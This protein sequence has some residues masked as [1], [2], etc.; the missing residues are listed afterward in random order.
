MIGLCFCAYL[1][2]RVAYCPLSL[3]NSMT[4]LFC[5]QVTSILL[6]RPSQF[7]ANKPAS[8][9]CILATRPPRHKRPTVCHGHYRMA[10]PRICKAVTNHQNNSHQL[11][12]GS[13]NQT[14]DSSHLAKL[15]IELFPL[16]A[17][18][19]FERLFPVPASSAAVEKVFSRTRS[20]PRSFGVV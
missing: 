8:E 20:R 14:A 1:Y 3:E 10:N 16:T 17:A 18:A 6:L 9:N 2:F 19:S 12:H 4:W 11:H 5:S 15:T 13:F 7:F